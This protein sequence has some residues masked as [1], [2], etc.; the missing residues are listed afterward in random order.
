M[1]PTHF[2]LFCSVLFIL[3]GTVSG[4]YFPSVWPDE[5]LFYSP[6]KELADSGMLATKVLEGLIPGMETHTYW[7]PPAFMGS[8]ALVFKIFHQ[9]IET[10]RLFSLSVSLIGIFIYLQ[11]AKISG[12]G[13]KG[14][15]LVTALLF[16]DILFFK[17]SH[18]A[19]MESLCMTAGA[20]AVY[21]CFS[22][23]REK[24]RL[25]ASG[26]FF[27]VSFLSHPIGII[28]FFP[29][30]GILYV[31][32][33]ITLRNIL[34]LA[35]GSF[36]L[37]FLWAVY[38][39][40]H[41]DMFLIQFG[42]QL[43]RKKDLFSKFTYLDKIKILFAGFQFPAWKMAVW[44]LTAGALVS[45]WKKIHSYFA[46][47]AFT[48]VFNTAVQLSS[49]E[50]W[51]V[52]YA[53]PALALCIG[54]LFE[55]ENRI[56]LTAALANM[57]F[58]TAVLGIAVFQTVSGKLKN[59]TDRFWNEIAEF[60]SE[61]SH[62][63]IQAIPDPYFYLSEKYPEKKLLEFI[64]GELPFPESTYSG[65]M[66]RQEVF[67]LYNTELA[68]PYIKRLISNPD[69]FQERE[70]VHSKVFGVSPEFRLKIYKKK[71]AKFPLSTPSP[72][73]ENKKENDSIKK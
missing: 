51:Y 52:Y 9:N 15:I 22:A 38:I 57:V 25:F 12:L 24:I 42:A 37:A 65:T 34:L 2:F 62:F 8:L 60:T 41:P 45:V 11:T 64:P 39:F 10:A 71:N 69:S 33:R 23:D 17:V 26:I 16:S 29:M 59:E 46:V 14:Q 21:F 35:A 61:K 58:N 47:F 67:L 72:P 56:G 3:L 68:N 7:M 44:T 5:V 28:H 70:F 48:A 13:K 36:P 66:D 18:T 20:A 43:A 63:Y 73:Q 55:A 40:P 49:S 53:V 32:K 50:S 27:S 31:Q 30:A 4:K 19:R 1:N 54:F 6:A